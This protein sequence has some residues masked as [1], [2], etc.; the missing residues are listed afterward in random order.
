MRTVFDRLIA[1][2]AQRR[3]ALAVLL[4]PDKLTSQA[5]L[6]NII[7]LI[8]NTETDLVLIGGSL[9]VENNF[10]Q[11]VREVKEKSKVPVVLFPGSA[12]QVDPHADAILFLSLISGRNAD[13]LIGQHVAA[14]PMLRESG[15]EVI[16]TGYLLID[17]GRPTTASYIS[18]TVP[19][20]AD[21]PE[22]AAVT[23]MAGEM[24]GLSVMY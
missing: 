15:I 21:K 16:P 5:S 1:L 14:A 7:S 2:R 9:M 13:L 23:A 6:D 20:P 8:N 17:G 19:V 22:I 12:S 18:Q 4:D 3:K 11:C 24:L 10:H